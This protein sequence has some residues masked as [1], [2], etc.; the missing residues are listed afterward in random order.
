M[1]A[2]IMRVLVALV[3]GLGSAMLLLVFGLFVSAM[4]D[5]AAPGSFLLILLAGLFTLGWYVILDRGGG[6]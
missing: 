5:M 2:I 6:S 3:L 1:T 4:T